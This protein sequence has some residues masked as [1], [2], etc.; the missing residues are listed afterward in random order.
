M[1]YIDEKSSPIASSQF[2]KD[3]LN[4]NF[5]QHFLN[6][7]TL[8][9]DRIFQAIEKA[10]DRKILGFI[11]EAKRIQD[12]GYKHLYCV[13]GSL[14]ELGNR[15]TEQYIKIGIQVGAAFL[16][17]NDLQSPVISSY[18]NVD[19][20]F[21][22]KL[23][24]N[25]NNIHFSGLFPSK[26]IFYKDSNNKFLS[27]AQ[28]FLVAIENILNSSKLGQYLF[29]HLKSEFAN[30]TNFFDCQTPNCPIKNKQ[31]IDLNHCQLCQHNCVSKINPI[32]KLIGE[33][34]SNSFDTDTKKEAQ[35]LMLMLEHTLSHYLSL[36]LDNPKEI[37]NNYL[38]IVDGPLNNELIGNFIKKNNT[39]YQNPVVSVQ[40][41]GIL[42]KS[43]TQVHQYL[44]QNHNLFA[45]PFKSKL[46]SF[47]NH[48]TGLVIA[49]DK[50]FKKDLGLST[51]Q[52]D[53]IYGNDYMYITRNEKEFV[54]NIPNYSTYENKQL[55]ILKSMYGILAST[56]T[57]L[58]YKNRGALIANV[59]AHENVSL[60]RKQTNYA[61]QAIENDNN[62][63]YKNKYKN[64]K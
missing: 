26:N 39:H 32:K 62:N 12:I 9:E 63:Q 14:I 21:I 51:Y 56:Y 31:Q 33:I 58:Y 30:I 10:F 50:D 41:T 20:T 8:S 4:S 25:K 11:N 27:T 57:N 48:D 19:P 24:R 49:L 42:N 60:N 6:D 53:G 44:R 3:H 54:F 47:I 36:N 15:E 28:S 45:E 43:L 23:Y 59:L 35:K 52:A 61:N 55:Q 22:A 46:S 40:K 7:L 29:L 17:I 64:I 34:N 1:A 2:N 38:V 16:D 37:E 5:S 13:D 18:G